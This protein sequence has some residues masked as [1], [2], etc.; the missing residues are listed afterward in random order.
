MKYVLRAAVIVVGLW[1]VGVGL[2]FATMFRPPE[3]FARGVAALPRIVMPL[4]PFASLW[5]IARAGSLDLGDPAPD[6]NLETLDRTSRVQLS[7]F[8]GAR[9]VVLVFGSYT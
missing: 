5:K 4:V 1:A 8:R 2:F 3:D 9:P 6:F 7:S